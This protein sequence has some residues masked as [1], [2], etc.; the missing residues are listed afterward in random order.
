MLSVNPAVRENAR[1]ATTW[2]RG[3]R[4]SRQRGE[5]E[6]GIERGGK[7]KEGMGYVHSSSY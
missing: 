4:G 3:E 1:M 2:G 6:G 7:G 5:W